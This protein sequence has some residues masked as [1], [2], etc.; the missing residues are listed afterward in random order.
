M[1]DCSI[2]KVPLVDAANYK[3]FPVQSV[4][5][6][7][8]LSGLLRFCLVLAAITSAS[9]QVKILQSNDDGW[10]AANIRAQ[11]NALN[12]AGYDVSDFFDNV[13]VPLTKVSIHSGRHCCS[14]GEQIWYRF[15]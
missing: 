2:Y 11:N 14:C 10:A 4:Q 5:V 15:L 8:A 12:A 1:V 7:M 3:L 9:A 13:T 6:A